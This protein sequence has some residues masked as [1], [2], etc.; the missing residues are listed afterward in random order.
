[1]KNGGSPIGNIQ[2]II[3][4]NEDEIIFPDEENDT[5]IKLDFDLNDRAIAILKD[6]PEKMFFGREFG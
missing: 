6:S 1:M 5:L 2:Y 4:L 3:T